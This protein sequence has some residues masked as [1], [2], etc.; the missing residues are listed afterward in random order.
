MEVKE[1]VNKKYAAAD[2]Q[3]RRRRKKAKIIA[4][5][6]S[7]TVLVL[8]VLLILSCTVFFPINK[9]SVKNNT[10][11]SADMITDFSGIEIGDKLFGISENKVK[12][13]LTTSLPYIKTIKLKRVPFDAVE[14]IVTETSDVY[15]YNQ[16]GKYY[17]SD[18]DNK[19]LASFDTKPQGITEIIV[20]NLPQIYTGY[21]LDIGEENLLLINEICGL[22]TN[23]NIKVD[24]LNISSISEITAMVNSRYEVNFGTIQ[25]IEQKTEHLRAMIPL[26]ISKNGEDATGSIDLS[27]WTSDNR[28][29]PFVLKEKNEKN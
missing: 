15:C 10:V 5:L 13:E 21:K 27:A 28:Q 20:G 17:T 14:I 26:I 22:L 9:I 29:I 7:I 3:A 24:T 6:C 12:S 16:S 23:A 2:R 4:L 1:S 25:N 8:G 19:V 11:Y 18:S